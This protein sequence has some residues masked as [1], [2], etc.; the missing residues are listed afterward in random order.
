MLIVEKLA[1]KEK[2]KE[3]N[4]ITS[5]PGLIKSRGCVVVSQRSFRPKSEVIRLEF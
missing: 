4:T 5:N 2:D 3:G 1:D